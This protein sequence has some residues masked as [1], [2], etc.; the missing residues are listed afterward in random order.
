MAPRNTWPN[1]VYEYILELK[2][3]GSSYRDISVKV[4]EK[5]DIDANEG[6]LKTRAYRYRKS[7]NTSDTKEP[8][9][10]KS[11]KKNPIPILKIPV[12]KISDTNIKINNQITNLLS[13]GKSINEVADYLDMTP[14]AVSNRISRYHLRDES[15]REISKED[16]EKLKE[17]YRH[18][19]RTTRFKCW[20]CNE[21]KTIDDYNLWYNRR[22][23]QINRACKK[24]HNKK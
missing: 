24:C 18:K 16:V 22:D 5:Y 11:V 12:K 21:D 19:Y 6:T 3:Q 8:A 9:K 2:D 1:E 10:E 20:V 7:K 4:K 14:G 13:N 17:Q 15:E 23:G